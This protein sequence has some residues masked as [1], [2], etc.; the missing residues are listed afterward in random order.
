[1]A[2]FGAV[3]WAILVT[4]FV[5]VSSIGPIFA[6]LNRSTETY[7]VGNRQFPAWL[8]GL[9]MF[10]TSISSITVVAVPADAYKA[11]YLRW[12][13]ALML[14]LGIYIGSKIFLPFY[15]RNKCTSAFEYLE[16]RFGTGVRTY[17]SVSFILFQL[18]RIATILFLVSIVFR[19]ITGGTPY[20]CIVAG[21]CVIAAYTVAG[22]ARAIVWAQFMQAFLLWTGAII[23][24]TSVIANIDGG[25]GA[26]FSIGWADG[27]F[28]LGDYNTATGALEHAKWFSLREKAIILILLGGLASWIFEYSANQNVVQKYVSAKNPREAFKS[29]WICCACSIP[30]WTLFMLLGTALYVFFKQNPDPQAAAILTGANGEKAEAILPYFCVKMIPSGLLGLVITGI[31]AAAMSASSASING[32]SAVFITDIYRRHLVKAST[33]KHYVLVARIVTALSCIAMMGLAVTFYTF[34]DLT[35][36][37]F[38]MKTA[39][40]LSGGMLSVYI[41]GF[42]TTRGSGRSIAVGIACTI[43]FTT[44]MTIVE[45]AKIQPQQLV[46]AIGVSERA[47]DLLLRPVHIYYVG[48][49]GNLITFL[50][51]YFLSALFEPKRDLTGLTFWTQIPEQEEV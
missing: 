2:R 15:R 11:A 18:V 47:A 9:A 8:L 3:D 40:I 4:Y 1:M 25:L 48:H 21:G 22:G 44:Y 6:R 32:I 43:V 24:F 51:G 41:L 13:P 46:D 20:A 36:Q 10:A 16:S 14:P 17:V 38:A 7:F 12:I 23:C 50:A 33:E 5:L 29:I 35:I 28:M 49:V 37:D 39:G 26:V 31:L 42:L 19:Q 30:T 27:K 34:S 45:F